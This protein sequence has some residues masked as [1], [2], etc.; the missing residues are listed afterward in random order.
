MKKRNRATAKISPGHKRLF[1]AVT[2]AIPVIFFVSLELIL[3]AL[4]YGPNLSLFGRQ[5]IR[6]EN[7]YV[8]NPDVK[9]RYFG[10][11]QFTPATSLHY[12]RMPKPP[13]VYRVFCLGGSTTTGYPYYFNASFSTFLAQRLMAL[14]PRKKIEVINLGMTATNSYTV[15]DITRELSQYQP[16]L[17]VDY[18]GH[19]EFYGALGVASN[20]TLGSSRF[21]TL[22]YLR[23]IHFRTFELLRDGI[24]Q[25]AG[26]F[27]RADTPA[28]SRGTMME[29][30]AQ[31]REIPYAGPLYDDAYKIF[32]A[33]LQDLREYCRSAGIPLILSTQVSNLRDQ[34]PF[35]SKFQPGTAQPQFLQAYNR[36]VEYQAKGFVD[37]AIVT[38]RSALALDSLYADAHYR[39]AQCLERIGRK[40]DALYEYA[41]SRDFDELRFRS[42]SKFNDLIR[43]MGGRGD[44]YVADIEEAFKSLSPD[45]LVGHNLTLDHLHPNSRGY[46]YIAREYVRVMRENRLLANKDEWHAVDTTSE[47]R[48]WQNRTVTKLDE[49]MAGQSVK[50]I[51]SGWP[52]KSTSAT[53]DFIPRSDTL[54]WIAQQLAIGKQGW[55]DSH[56][57]AIDFYR[58]RG[59]LAN[60]ESEYKAIIDIYPHILQPYLDLASAYF[61][62]RR[63]DEMKSILLRSVQLEPT[64]LAYNALGNILLDQGDPAGALQY[65]EKVDDSF[66]SPVERLQNGFRISYAYA[67]AGQVEKAKARLTEILKIKPDFQ[68][69]LLLLADLNK[70]PTKKSSTAK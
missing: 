55:L 11:L 56:K 58:R 17:L 32:Q 28:V 35:V 48:L 19:N 39:L 21:A 69:A 60:V 36:G 29:T 18:D 3:R 70:Q 10:S 33:N 4:N 46:F 34:P 62:E 45:S 12:F 43:S 26:F 5:E 23:M 53:I 14:F 6:G 38:F 30:L 1:L 63:F 57:E 59:D 40:Q 31:G 47:D 9:F 42:D 25:L 50:V 24:E 20:Q 51:M 52:F 41:R 66:Q 37:S 8:M 44:C 15:L 64:P 67:K 27:G 7:Y 68:P 22:L 61:Q 2:V 16:D 49:E 13:G 65:F 54:E